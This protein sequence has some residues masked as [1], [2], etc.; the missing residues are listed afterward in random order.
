MGAIGCAI[1]AE[2]RAAN[3]QLGLERKLCAA[4][5]AN[6]LLTSPFPIATAAGWLPDLSPPHKRA[7]I[8][9][10]ITLLLL[11]ASQPTVD[12]RSRVASRRRPLAAAISLNTGTMDGPRPHSSPSM[13]GALP[14][15]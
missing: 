10:A 5:A 15:M 8:A 13:L 7:Q 4:P 2:G 14:S 3:G 11:V 1:A 12:R 6:L 9:A